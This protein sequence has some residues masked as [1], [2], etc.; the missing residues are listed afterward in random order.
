MNSIGWHHCNYYLA[1]INMTSVSLTPKI[2]IRTHKY[3]AARN[4]AGKHIRKDIHTCILNKIP[5][6]Q[7]DRCRRIHELSFSTHPHCVQ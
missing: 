6:F 3:I 1:C 4:L 7:A 2:C 5:C